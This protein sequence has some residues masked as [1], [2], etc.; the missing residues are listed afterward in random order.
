MTRNQTAYFMACFAERVKPRG[1]NGVVAVYRSDAVTA[2]VTVCL[3]SESFEAGHEKHD[4]AQKRSVWQLRPCKLLRASFV[5]LGAF[6]GNFRRICQR[7]T[8]RARRGD[9]LSQEPGSFESALRIQCLPHE[10]T[11]RSPLRRRG[12]GWDWL[13]GRRYVRLR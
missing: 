11:Q 9:N 3:P 12:S 5:F 2:S 10:R 1:R 6:R 4:R 8:T 7:K 13:R